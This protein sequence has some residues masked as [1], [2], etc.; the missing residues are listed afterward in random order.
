M[1]IVTKVMEKSWNCV[2]KNVY[3]PCLEH[4]SVSWFQFEVE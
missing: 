4:C 1:E 2:G 3:E